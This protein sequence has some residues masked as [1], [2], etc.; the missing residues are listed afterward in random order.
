MVE[1]IQL[2][3]AFT[4]RYVIPFQKVRAKR[5]GGERIAEQS[6]VK[7][8]TTFYVLN[9]EVTELHRMKILNNVQK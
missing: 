6:V 5:E 1:N 8:L 9:S 4:W 2:I 3:R 7:L